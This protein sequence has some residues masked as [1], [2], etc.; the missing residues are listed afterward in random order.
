MMKTLHLP[1][2]A[3][4]TVRIRTGAAIRVRN[5]GNR[6]F[7]A[8]HLLYDAAVVDRMIENTLAM[9]SNVLLAP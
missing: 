6:I 8:L 9:A 1:N 5:T 3:Q 7:G 2:L 4:N